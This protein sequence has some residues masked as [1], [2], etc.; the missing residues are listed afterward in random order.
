MK[1]ANEF[2]DSYAMLQQKLF[3][4]L[5]DGFKTLRPKLMEAE[6]DPGKILEWRLQSLSQMGALTSKVIDLVSKQT[7]KSKQAIYQ[8]IKDNGI[9]VTKQT[10]RQLAHDLK[11]KPKGISQDTMKIIDSYAS[12]TFKQIDNNVNQTL[13]S[14][15]FNRN[16]VLR[17]YQKIVNKTVLDVTVGKK[18]PRKA[19]DDTLIKLH[20][21]GMGVTLQDSA[22]RER[23]VES[24]VR[25]VIDTT[26]QRT[27]N[28]ARMETMKDC[29]SGLAIMS[30]HPAARPACAQIQG[31]VVCVL[32]TTDDNYKDDYDNYP[33]I[34]DYGYGDPGGCFG[35]N[36]GHM[37]FPYIEGVSTNDEPD[38]DP[39]EAIENEN[40]VQKQRYMQRQI[41]Q[42]KL[43]LAVANH[44][45]DSQ[46]AAQI[47]SSIRGY[48]GKVRKIT[49]SHGFLTRDRSY[50]QVSHAT[51]QQVIS[52][53]K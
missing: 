27:F 36:C 4:I 11:E 17:T 50:E 1:Q 47:K 8:I 5:V 51:I 26:A 48:Q 22:G 35:I 53:S 2:G 39:D 18:T 37:L 16:P 21:K 29:G 40:I 13:L 32:E 23:S 3:Y 34:Y 44:I 9:K 33:N 41:R 52:N 31:Q 10:N 43:D 25:T 15:N 24:Y 20:Q 42:K 28:D 14:R 49:G 19:L 6:K 38:Y 7:G 46:K 45:G 12:Q 30:A